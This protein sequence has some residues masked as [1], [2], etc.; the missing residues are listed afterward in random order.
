MQLFV[1]HYPCPCNID[2]LLGWLL[3]HTYRLN[4]LGIGITQ[5]FDFLSN[6]SFPWNETRITA[7]SN[8]YMNSRTLHTTEYRC[9]INQVGVLFCNCNYDWACTYTMYCI[10]YILPLTASDKIVMS[11]Q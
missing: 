2:Q 6:E 7:L 3:V 4:E 5:A 11:A 1:L 9:A 10:V 8:R